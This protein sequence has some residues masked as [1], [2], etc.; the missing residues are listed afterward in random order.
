MPPGDVSLPDS[1]V[2]G[3]GAVRPSLNTSGYG[4]SNGGSFQTQTPT[5]PA[6]ST[7]PFDSPRTRPW[8]ASSTGPD[9]GQSPV[10]GRPI[11]RLDSNPVDARDPTTPQD[12]TNHW[13]NSGPLE[14]PRPNGRPHAKSPGSS[15]RIC[16]KCNEPLTGQ[17][18]RALMAT[19][20][21]ECFKCEVRFSALSLFHFNILIT[22]I[23]L[24]A[25]SSVQVLPRRCRRWKRAISIM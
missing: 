8:N 19:Y 24:W 10:D 15:S 3:N 20:H 16:K 25:N 2:P 9:S 4:G 12:R 17:F 21:L 14:K 5:S 6:D 7:V 22:P 11:R 23:G 1:L 13:E 18:V